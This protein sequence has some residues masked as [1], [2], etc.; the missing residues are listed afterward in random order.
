MI[1]FNS[2][3][4]YS[5]FSKIKD[6]LKQLPFKFSVVAISETWFCDGKEN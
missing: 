3:S 2:M 4:L 6:Y 5:N 1:H